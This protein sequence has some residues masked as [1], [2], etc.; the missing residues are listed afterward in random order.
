MT[1]N[2]KHARFPLSPDSSPAPIPPPPSPLLPAN[3]PLQDAVCLV[4]E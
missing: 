4:R 2:P 3:S 1:A